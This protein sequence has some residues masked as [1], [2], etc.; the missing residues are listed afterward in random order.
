MS[1]SPRLL[2]GSA[3]FISTSA[4][5]APPPAQA[6]FQAAPQEIGARLSGVCM[7]AGM[8]VTAADSMQ[9]LCAKEV[10]GFKGILTQVLIGNSYSTTPI[11]YARFQLVPWN[12]GTRI[13]VS[14]WVE[15]QMA[16]GQV[17]RVPL[18]GKKQT[19]SMLQALYNLGGTAIPPLS[20]VASAKASTSTPIAAA[21]PQAVLSGGGGGAGDEVAGTIDLGGGIKLVP[22]KT[23]SG[24]CIKAPS[25]Y[26]GTGSVNRPS[27][28]TAKPRCGLN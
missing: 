28:T 26:I 12:N 17:R 18:N 24:Y 4:A 1:K 16:F 14:E 3:V 21:A 20:G 19:N 27:V 23:L 11:Q 9:V 15:T 22:A 7:D 13:Q 8:T 5:T 25:G 2:L 6:Y 10:S